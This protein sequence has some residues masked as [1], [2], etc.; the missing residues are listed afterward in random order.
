MSTNTKISNTT[1]KVYSATTKSNNSVIQRTQLK[2]QTQKFERIGNNITDGMNGALE[3][4]MNGFSA[5]L[6]NRDQLGNQDE[7]M[8]VDVTITKRKGVKYLYIKNSGAPANMKKL[9]DYGEANHDTQL[10]QF[11]TGFKSAISYFNPTNDGWA[12]Y[13]TT[14]TQHFK[15]QAPYDTDMEVLEITKWPFESWVVSCVEIRIDD[16][17]ALSGLTKS[18]CGYHF[19]PA[20]TEHGLNLTFNGYNVKAIE[21]K[22][23]RT[24]KVNETVT[25][26]GQDV[27]MQSYTHILG[28]ESDGA[29]YFPMGVKGQ[30]VYLYVNG[31]F[32]AH[33][34]VNLIRKKANNDCADTGSYLQAHPVMNHLIAVVNIDTPANRSL[35]IPFNSNKTTIKWQSSIGKAYRQAIDERVGDFFREAY[36]AHLEAEQ[37]KL[38]D[39]VCKKFGYRFMQYEREFCC[40]KSRT[41]E[42]KF[43]DAA[44]GH[45]KDARGHLV[46]SKVETIVEFKS[47]KFKSNHVD[48]AIG[49]HTLCVRN[50]GINPDVI[51]VGWGFEEEALGQIEYYRDRLGIRIDIMDMTQ[52]NSAA[53]R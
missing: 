35:D 12:F 45:E 1:E 17:E 36:L 26:L 51:L 52:F 29:E 37:R 20:I 23:C 40:T 34:G 11:G 7:P 41:K 6:V 53:L 30:G 48:E 50:H 13:T 44:I 47:G 43:A 28:K 16:E 25:V 22:G 33:L 31:C 10:N 2:I 9:L 19:A 8:R 32:A 27:M 38:I 4:I 21:P 42:A 3:L 49:Y 24:T 46:P 14:G 15:V 18:N 5:C 39:T